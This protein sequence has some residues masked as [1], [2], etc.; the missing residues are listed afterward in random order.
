MFNC[1]IFIG[2]NNKKKER[3]AMN[4]SSNVLTIKYKSDITLYL[5][6][7]SI[8]GQYAVSNILSKYYQNI[9]LLF[10]EKT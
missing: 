9:Q 10:L 4:F 3:Y 7:L 8:Q 2:V 5:F 1:G 6:S